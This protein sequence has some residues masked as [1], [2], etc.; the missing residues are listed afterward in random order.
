[1]PSRQRISRE[2]WDDLPTFEYERRSV[3]W[4]IV[5]QP[6]GFITLGAWAALALA[7]LACVGRR[8]VTILTSQ[9]TWMSI[10]ATTGTTCGFRARTQA[11]GR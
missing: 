8:P 1:M 6:I 2:H 9:F 7:T 3:A 10:A 11:S 5:Q 4:A